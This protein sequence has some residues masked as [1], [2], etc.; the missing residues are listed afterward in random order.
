VN[1]PAKFGWPVEFLGYPVSDEGTQPLPEAED[2]PLFQN[3]RITKEIAAFSNFIGS[4]CPRPPRSKRHST[5]FFTRNLRE[6][7][8]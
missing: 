6:R 1:N 7:S 3:V 4:S 2:S 8:Y 5:I